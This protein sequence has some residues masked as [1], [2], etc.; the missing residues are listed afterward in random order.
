MDN[1][2]ARLKIARKAEGIKRQESAADI[3]NIPYGTYRNIEQ[4]MGTT[5]ANIEQIICNPTFAKYTLWLLTGN[6]NGTC[7]Q[8]APGGISTKAIEGEKI[9]FDIPSSALDATEQETIPAKITRDKSG[10][11][12]VHIPPE[13]LKI[14]LEKNP[15]KLF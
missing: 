1:L 5:L 4:G 10:G 8:I 14:Y 7:E 6:A 9:A 3:F 11:L 2:G 13:E 15:L 12:F